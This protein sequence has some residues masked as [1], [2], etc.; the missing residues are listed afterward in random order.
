ME[1]TRLNDAGTAFEPERN[2]LTWAYGLDGGGS[3]AADSKGNVYVAWHGTGPND[4]KGEAGRGVF[5]AHSVNEGKT[6]AK[7]TQ[8]NPPMTGACGCCGMRVMATDDG[9]IYLLYRAAIEGVDR[10]MILLAGGGKSKS[11][12]S[13]VLSPWNLKVCPM[14]T[15]FLAASASNVLAA[16]ENQEQVGF[17]M[18]DPAAK[19]TKSITPSGFGKRKHPALAQNRNGDIVLAWTE[20]TGWMKGGTFAWQT[21]DK[22]GKPLGGL[23]NG[24]GVPVWG[25]VAVVAKP[26]GEFVLI[27]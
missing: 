4:Q 23:T 11:Y 20:D 9:K 15:T 13:M 18:V 7:E 25:L 12:Q 16:W 14:S 1:Y 5:I 6:F 27:Y 21:F 24:D 2:V 3:V 26:T 22:E 19:L 8:A 10:D 17:S